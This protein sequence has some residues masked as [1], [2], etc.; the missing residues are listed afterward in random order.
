MKSVAALA[1]S[2]TAIFADNRRAYALVCV[3]HGKLL[4]RA[5][6]VVER[7]VVLAPLALRAPGTL[8]AGR[9]ASKTSRRA[10]RRVP[11]PPR[12][13]TPCGDGALDSQRGKLRRYTKSATLSN[14][15]SNV[16]SVPIAPSC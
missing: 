6:S 1:G 3:S 4:L 10:R 8:N 11:R 16:A 2:T 13:R 7:P 15:L 14:L 12:N 9:G 5:E